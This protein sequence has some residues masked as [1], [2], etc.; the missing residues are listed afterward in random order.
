MNA[1]HGGVKV[2]TYFVKTNWGETKMN[3]VALLLPHRILG[4]PII[5]EALNSFFYDKQK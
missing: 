1:D 5:H 2:L 3:T 4:A